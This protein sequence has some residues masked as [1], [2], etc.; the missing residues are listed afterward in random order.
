MSLFKYLNSK[1]YRI[2]E[3][4]VKT[5]FPKYS[6]VPLSGPPQKQ[7]LLNTLDSTLF[8]FLNFKNFK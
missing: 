7:T 4:L 5:L 1:C 3:H 8:N 2:K 6:H